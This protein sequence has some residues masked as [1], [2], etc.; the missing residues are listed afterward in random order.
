M[1]SK[2]H[3]GRRLTR[4]IKRKSRRNKG[5]KRK[6]VRHN[7]KGWDLVATTVAQNFKK[8]RDVQALSRQRNSF[9]PIQYVHHP[10]H[11]MRQG[12]N[13]LTIK[14]GNSA[15]HNLSSQPSTATSHAPPPPKQL[16]HSLHFLAVE[17]RAS[18]LHFSKAL[19]NMSPKSKTSAAILVAINARDGRWFD[20]KV[21]P[22]CVSSCRSTLCVH[23]QLCTVGPPNCSLWR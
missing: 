2:G 13:Q 14:V 5:R 3:R 12:S 18:S 10:K 15:I 23:S 1:G 22:R 7:H 11:T 21:V 17:K 19:S 9:G 8:P 4:R 20:A 16:R 6:P